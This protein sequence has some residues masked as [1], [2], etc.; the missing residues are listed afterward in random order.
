CGDPADRHTYRIAVR[1]FPDGGG[2]SI[3]V[4]DDLRVG[5]PVSIKGPRNAFPLAIPGHGSHARS[6]RFIAAGIGITPILPML[7]AADRF[8][9]D[10]S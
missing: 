2:G 8:G 4:H 5:D 9:L 1:R 3:E 10:W 6:I 7:A